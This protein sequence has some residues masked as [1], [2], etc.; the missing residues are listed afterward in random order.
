MV[1]ALC[2]TTNL[3]TAYA[4]VIGG[5]EFPAGAASFADAVTSFG[6]VIFG[7]NPTS[8]HLGAFNAL[9]PPTGYR[10]PNG[11]TS[12]HQRQPWTTIPS[13]RL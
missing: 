8:P 6:P 7:G 3:A 11:S 13:R 12:S 10:A 4:V 1:L 2:E 9:G 5:V